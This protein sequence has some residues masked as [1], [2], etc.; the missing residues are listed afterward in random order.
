MNLTPL[1]ST[2]S[3]QEEIDL[4]KKVS[5]LFQHGTYTADLFSE[6]FLSWHEQQLRNDF[7]PNVMDILTDARNQANKSEAAR[8]QA[9]M[10]LDQEKGKLKVLEAQRAE[11]I[12]RSD[13]LYNHLM[14]NY[15]HISGRLDE[16]QDKLTEAHNKYFQATD[17][18]KDLESL[19]IKLKAQLFDLQNK[20]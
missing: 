20:G 5:T 16:T 3:K 14:D 13:K 15:N 2:A 19:V 12:T 11:E 8:L 18:L 9:L 6:M 17:Q 4:L 1:T 7:P 10:Q